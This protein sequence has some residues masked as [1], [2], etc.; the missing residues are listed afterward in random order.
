MEINLLKINK[1][2]PPP[3]WNLNTLEVPLEKLITSK[4]PHK[5]VA[6]LTGKTP[7]LIKNIREQFVPEGEFI[8]NTFVQKRSLERNCIHRFTLFLADRFFNLQL[9]FGLNPIHAFIKAIDIVGCAPTFIANKSDDFH[10]GVNL[11]YWLSLKGQLPAPQFTHPVKEN[12]F[13]ESFLDYFGNGT[14]AP[15]PTIRQM[16]VFPVSPML[17]DEH[18]R[19]LEAIN[20]GIANHTCLKTVVHNYFHGVYA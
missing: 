20:N 7:Y 3:S 1:L 6:E 5:I 11:F 19:M 14:Q 10:L 15:L 9:C 16:G 8:P 18:R 12:H 13:P 17:D 2:P 4:L